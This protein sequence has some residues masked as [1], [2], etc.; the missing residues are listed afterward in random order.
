VT[1]R[2]APGFAVQAFV[3]KRASKKVTAD[4]QGTAKLRLRGRPGRAKLRVVAFADD[5]AV[6][7]DAKKALR[8]R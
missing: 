5:G 3:G 6:S 1:A 8:L 2:T 4:A 7:A